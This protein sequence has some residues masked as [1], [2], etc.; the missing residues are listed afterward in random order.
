MSGHF[1]TKV[2]VVN[3]KKKKQKQGQLLKLYFVNYL[4]I[5]NIPIRA[6]NLWSITYCIKDK[7]NEKIGIFSKFSLL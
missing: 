4:N 6:Y 7:I 1:G 2:S 3:I 5:I